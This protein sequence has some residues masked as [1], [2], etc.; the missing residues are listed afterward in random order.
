MC[1]PNELRISCRRSA[2]RPYK[3]TFP[4]SGLKEVDARA[5]PPRPC[6]LH[7]R[8]RRQPEAELRV[9]PLAPLR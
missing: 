6:R 5:G 4:L 9:L 7:A 3:S 1:A 2:H 8:V